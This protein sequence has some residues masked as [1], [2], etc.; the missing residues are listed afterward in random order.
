MDLLRLVSVV[1]PVVQL[2]SHPSDG[3]SCQ[4]FSQGQGLLT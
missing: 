2:A 4:T 1:L 3:S